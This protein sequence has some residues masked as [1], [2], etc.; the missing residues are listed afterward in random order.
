[1]GFL[2]ALILNSVTIFIYQLNSFLILSRVRVQ[3]KWIEYYSS[4]LSSNKIINLLN[5]WQLKV[6]LS[7]KISSWKNIVTF[8]FWRK[9]FHGVSLLR[10]SKKVK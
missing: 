2:L 3:I 1:M 6:V 5:K 7:T 9:R 4:I 10:Y 8:L